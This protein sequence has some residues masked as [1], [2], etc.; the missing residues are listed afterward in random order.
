MVRWE[1]VGETS[2][3]P[4]EATE[5]RGPG[6]GLGRK[7]TWGRKNWT[8]PLQAGWA[9]MGSVVSGGSWSTPQGLHSCCSAHTLPASI[10]MVG[11]PH[12]LGLGLNVTFP[13]GLPPLFCL[14]TALFSIGAS[15]FFLPARELNICS[16][17]SSSGRY[18]PWQ[19][20]TLH[21]C[22]IHYCAHR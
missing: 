22:F 16:S 7:P 13:R 2:E 17:S 1:V 12:L 15:S 8:C 20:G 18:P 11:W 21:I 3:G 10:W 9:Q 5:E 6:W 19:A 14:V 4:E